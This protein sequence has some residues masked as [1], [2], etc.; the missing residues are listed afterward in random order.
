MKKAKT[1]KCPICGRPSA[2]EHRPFCT[3][4]CAEV[5]LN[6]WLGG[7]YVVEGKDGEALG[8]AADAENPAPVLEL[9]PRKKDRL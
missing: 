3:Q 2:A 6:R 5:D 7:V 4:R 8:E 1:G 9:Y